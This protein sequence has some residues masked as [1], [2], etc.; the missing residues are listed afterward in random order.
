MNKNNNTYHSNDEI[1][2]KDLLKIIWGKK[3]FIACITS[4]FAVFSV[5]YSLYLPNTYTS[6]TLL[7]PTSQDE[8]LSSSLG[9]LSGLASFAGVSIPSGNITKSQIAV[10]RIQSHEFFSKH[11]LPYIKLENLMAVQEWE[12][13]SNSIVYNKKIFDIESGSWLRKVSFPKSIKPSS[14]EAFKEYQKILNIEESKETGLV[15]MSIKHQSPY[16][17]KNWIDIIVY[18]INESM[19]SIDIKDAQNSIDF[20]NQSASDVK[21]QSI[22]EVISK[23]L[24]S[25]MQT[26]MLATSNADYIFKIINSSIVPEEK[27]GPNRALICIMGT[28]IGAFMSTILSF[29]QYFRKPK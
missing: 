8:S 17:A 27:S 15:Y 4:I 10:K 23:L 1:E 21:I 20:L 26:L 14:Q 19:R 22:K 25:Q 28:L 12:P 16:V 24:E 2:L 3:I 6:S 29:I 7:S 5:M 13:H 18:N 9:G 11:F